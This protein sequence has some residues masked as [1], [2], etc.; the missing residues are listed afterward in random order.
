M[1]PTEPDSKLAERNRRT[2]EGIASKYADREETGLDGDMEDDAVPPAEPDPG[3]RARP[4]MGTVQIVEDSP[5]FVGV[6]EKPR[7]LEDLMALFP[8]G[9]E[10]QGYYVRVVR[11]SPKKWG[12]I[13]C[14]GV[15]RPITEGM[16]FE[17]FKREYGGGEYGLTVYGPP[18]SKGILDV[19]TGRMRPKA[20]TNEVT[21]TVPFMPPYGC[22]PNPDA[23]WDG[24]EDGFDATYDDNLEEDYD[25]MTRAP[26]R[27]AASLADAKIVEAQIGAHERAQ[28]REARKREQLEQ[29]VL[30]LPQQMGATIQPILDTVNAQSD[31]TLEFIQRNAAAREE[32]QRERERSER[33]RRIQAEEEAKRVENESRIAQQRHYEEERL[34]LEEERRRMEQRP[35]GAAE[36]AGLVTSLASVLKPSDDGGRTETLQQQ[37]AALTDQHRREIDQLHAT[38]R[39]EAERNARAAADIAARAEQAHMA[40]LERTERRVSDAEERAGKLTRDAEERSERR[41]KEVTE[42]AEREITRAKEDGEKSVREIERVLT[43]RMEDERRSHE[44]EVRLQKEMYDMRLGT[45]KGMSET[46]VTTLQTEIER[47]RAEKERLRKEADEKGDLPAQIERFAGVAG[48]LGWVK[49]DAPEAAPDWKSM[50]FGVMTNL[51]QQFPEILKNAGEA[52]AKSRGSATPPPPQMQ[53]PQT[54]AGYAQLPPPQPDHL[55]S[56]PE[57]ARRYP[58]P[59]RRRGGGFGTEDGPE[60]VNL[61]PPPAPRYQ[62]IVMPNLDA[63]PPVGPPQMDSP[64]WGPPPPAPSPSMMPPPPAPVAAPPVAAQPS[65]EVDSGQMDQVMMLRRGLEGAFESGQPVA[66]FAGILVAQFGKEQLAGM[67]Q[68]VDEDA[69]VGMISQSPGGADSPLLRRD[70]RKYLSELLAATKE[71]V[72][73]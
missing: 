23:G 15:Q 37:I 38:Y 71:M 55:M 19:R 45:E 59:L 27:R 54:M 61:A 11:K 56:H 65:P 6:V 31:R 36:I 60:P 22:P 50:A 39:A 53:G 26:I 52:V 67:M 68:M 18:R 32:D 4:T 29:Q 35:T 72:S 62:P 46:R 24:D 5:D 69:I 3:R 47:E 57:P 66:Q 70:G 64:Q 41:V 17:Q 13:D 14:A 10:G 16:T 9:H 48:S 49:G 33:E 2:L 28:E 42:R 63:P 44:R 8:I 58:G 12:T 34:R 25:M 1:P 40:A 30:G 51:A 43:A 20:L 7:S 21:F 73:G